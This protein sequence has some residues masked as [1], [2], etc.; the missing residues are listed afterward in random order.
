MLRSQLSML[1]GLS[2][3]DK[4]WLR[5]TSWIRDFMAAFDRLG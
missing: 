3:G 2:A 5:C 4:R 1:P